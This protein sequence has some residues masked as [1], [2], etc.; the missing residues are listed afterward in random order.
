MPRQGLNREAVVQAAADLIEEEGLASFSMGGLARRLAVRPSSLYNHVQSM[1]GLLEDVA[2]LAI[3]RLTQ[4][5]REACEGKTGEAALFALAEAYR[6]YARAHPELYRAV[7]HAGRWG[8]PELEARAGDIV[9]PIMEV[10]AGFGLD[11]TEQRHWQRVLRS[12][13]HGFA[14][15]E[16]A[17]AFSHFPEDRDESYRLA[18]QCV[19]GGLRR[20]GRKSHEDGRTDP[21]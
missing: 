6:R 4:A 15:H 13:M 7:M 17:G 18:V 3:D 11:E 12:V 19:A 21:V 1:D 8:R 5:E 16:Q 10:L 9:R 2:A 20:A 14:A